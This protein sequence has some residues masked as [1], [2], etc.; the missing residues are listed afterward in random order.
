MICI[1]GIN[2]SK[3]QDGNKDGTITIDPLNTDGNKNFAEK[4]FKALLRHTHCE[5]GKKK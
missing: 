5:K 4:I 1:I 2:F 3:L